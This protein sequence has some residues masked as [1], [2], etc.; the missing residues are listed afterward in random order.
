MSNSPATPVHP[1]S[2]TRRRFAY[3]G[4]GG[5][6]RTF[7]DPVATQYSNEAEIVGL[8]DTSLVRATYHGARLQSSFG[9]APVPVYVASDFRRM[10]E[11]TRPD[12]V[13]VCTID[14]EHDRYIVEA[15]H[16]GCDVVTEKPMTVTAGKCAAIFA[17]AR[18]T[19]RTVRVA[20]NYRWAPG[21]TKVREILA[22]RTIGAVRHVTMEYLLNTSH[23][24]DYFRRWH[25]QKEN[26]GGLLV[27][28]ATHH[29]DLINWWIDAIPETVFAQ[30]TLAYYGR[31]NAIRRG[32]EQWT[33]YPRYLGHA[34]KDDPFTY[35]YTRSMLQDAEYER[36]LY[37]G[38]AENESGYVRDQNV[39]R[40]GIT[41]E[42]TMNVLV[43][44]RTGVLLNYSLNAYSPY[45]GFR[46]AFTGD[47]GRVEYQENHGAHIIPPA[48]GAATDSGHAAPAIVPELRVFPHFKESYVV[49]IDLAS[50]GH[51]GADPRLQE[52]IF[53]ARPPADPFQRAAGHE[54]GAA[55]TLV[56][57]A[58]NESMARRQPVNISELFPLRPDAKRLSQLK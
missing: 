57:I 11:E 30:G 37:L 32:D 52:Q 45:E 19:G 7:L 22:D 40:S 31:E 34:A 8:C 47:R 51:G 35:D 23:G 39:F 16:A 2:L 20:F 55:S 50:G 3:V 43:W 18:E 58:A 36:N 25:A 29:F 14:R 41:I 33:R 1:R 49:K 21:A 10:L 44:Y 54:Q 5:R 17:A 48:N 12:V 9:Y 56:G 6:V 15:L 46:V 38:A 28:K 13:V 4:T 26:S 42:D 27:H 24:A 53:S